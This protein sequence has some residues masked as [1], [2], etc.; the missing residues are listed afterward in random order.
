[1][2]ERKGIDVLRFVSLRFII[3][4]PRAGRLVLTQL[5]VSHA[6]LANAVRLSLVR[7]S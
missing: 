3:S 4:G 6:A 1:M 7:W 2:T 5:R